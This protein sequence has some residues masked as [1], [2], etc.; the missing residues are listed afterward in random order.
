MFQF[1]IALFL[2]LLLAALAVVALKR[3]DI[4]GEGRGFPRTRGRK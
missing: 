3:R 1:I 2:L 4:D